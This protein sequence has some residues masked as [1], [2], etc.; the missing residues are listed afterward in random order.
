M[1]S[2]ADWIGTYRDAILAVVDAPAVGED[3]DIGA[4]GAEFA[5]SLRW[6][7]GLRERLA[8]AEVRTLAKYLQTVS[9]AWPSSWLKGQALPA[10]QAP[11]RKN[12]QGT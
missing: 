7:V 3:V 12:L 5:V 11:W 8:S 10:W 1:R 4:L 9:E 2:E 6:L